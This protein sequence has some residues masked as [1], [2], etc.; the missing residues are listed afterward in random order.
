MSGRLRDST[1]TRVLLIGIVCV[2]LAASTTAVAAAGTNGSTD[3]STIAEDRISTGEVH[4]YEDPV[5]ETPEYPCAPYTTG[6]KIQ[7][8]LTDPSAVDTVSLSIQ[9]TPWSTVADVATADDPT[10]SVVAYN[11]NCRGLVGN[12]QVSGLVV[13]GETPYTLEYVSAPFPMTPEQLV[14]EVTP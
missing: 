12:L 13:D 7:L 4:T 11:Y 2:L 9:E 1:T 3:D 5:V 6:Y 10:A 8:T 14:D